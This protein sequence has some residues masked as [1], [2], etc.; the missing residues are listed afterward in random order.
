[1]ADQN[2]LNAVDSFMSFNFSVAEIVNAL[3]PQGWG[4]DEIRQAVEQLK[5][6]RPNYQPLDEISAE[7]REAANKAADEI[8][9]EEDYQE[10]AATIPEEG[11]IAG[12]GKRYTS[13]LVDALVSPIVAFALFFPLR[14]VIRASLGDPKL[15][16]L[17]LLI[18]IW[19]MYDVVQ[20]I[21]WEQTLGNRLVKTK[22]EMASGERIKF[23]PALIRRVAKFIPF[24][25]ISVLLDSS[26][27]NQ[28][29]HDKFADVVVVSTGE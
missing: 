27:Q 24:A 1:M 2:L 18:L 22:V 16:L 12:L 11:L 13:G 3:A 4:E 10:D 9:S 7:T 29:W 17:I 5:P 6:R 28:F 23:V 8:I 15:V 21:L 25:P 20:L 14:L 26:G 19:L